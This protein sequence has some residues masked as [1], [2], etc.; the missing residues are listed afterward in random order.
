MTC[1]PTVT[2][3]KAD[4]PFYYQIVEEHTKAVLFAGVVRDPNAY[5][6]AEIGRAGVPNEDE[7]S[8]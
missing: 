4:R 6:G 7:Y 1:F 2:K 5:G 8:E 3:I